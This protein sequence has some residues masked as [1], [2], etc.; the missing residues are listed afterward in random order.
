MVF[1]NCERT[2]A[3]FYNYTAWEERAAGGEP[4][5]GEPCQGLHRTFGKS[6]T[7]GTG[8]AARWARGLHSLKGFVTLILFLGKI[9]RNV[10]EDLSTLPETARQTQ[11]R[12]FFFST[13]RTT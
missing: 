7:L 2:F 8:G 6:G 12:R 11:A 1:C 3:T 4:L 9:R 5:G 10:L 13:T